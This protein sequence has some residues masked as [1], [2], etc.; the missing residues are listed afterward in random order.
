MKSGCYCCGKSPCSDGF[1]LACLEEYKEILQD[2]NDFSQ[3]ECPGH[4]VSR[5]KHVC[6]SFSATPMVYAWFTRDGEQPPP[7]R[8]YCALCIRQI[9][10]AIASKQA[11]L[12]YVKISN[13]TLLTKCC[14]VIG[15]NPEL[16]LHLAYQ[17]NV[18]EHL[19]QT[20]HDLIPYSEFASEESF[21]DEW[22]YAT[23]GS[24]FKKFKK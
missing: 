4:G 16:V 12:E 24:A 7:P 14:R 2:V 11:A 3:Y 10:N 9:R 1:C 8:K 17:P 6:A 20:I 23:I 19:W 15:Q 13:E 18:P 5:L 22:K 21:K